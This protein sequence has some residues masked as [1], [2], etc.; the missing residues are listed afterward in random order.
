MLEHI[1]HAVGS[2]HLISFQQNRA[3]TNVSNVSVAR[4]Q[5]QPVQKVARVRKVSSFVEILQRTLF[6][7]CR[8][9]HSD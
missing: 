3:E 7:F 1:W 4:V 2:S 6:F 5:N 8:A 9:Q